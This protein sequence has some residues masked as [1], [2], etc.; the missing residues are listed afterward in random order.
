ML[1]FFKCRLAHTYILKL[2]DTWV[3]R[4]VIHGWLVGEWLGNSG[5]RICLLFFLIT[6]FICLLFVCGRS[7]KIKERDKD[8]FRLK[9]YFWVLWLYYGVEC[10]PGPVEIVAFPQDIFS[11]YKFESLSG[12][13]L[14]LAG[15]IA[16]AK[17]WD[18]ACMWT[19]H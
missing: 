5:V 15:H 12:F 14:L 19:P 13:S 2:I 17:S 11:H 16:S 9:L 18:P 1:V 3:V 6:P 4:R 7:N 10:F 8:T